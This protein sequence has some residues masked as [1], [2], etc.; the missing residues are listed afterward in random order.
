MNSQQVIDILME[1]V[2]ATAELS[3]PLLVTALVV[4][5]II[6][7]FQAAT[8]INEATLSFLPKIAAM[9]AVF[10]IMSPWMVRRMTTYTQDIFKKI[11]EITKQK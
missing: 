6:S 3:L 8:Q 10:A 1:L 5:L 11:P 9:I 2:Y 4:G 7:I